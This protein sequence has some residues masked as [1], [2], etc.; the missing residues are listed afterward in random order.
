[1]NRAYCRSFSVNTTPAFINIY[2]Y[3]AQSFVRMLE[4]EIQENDGWMV[5][6]K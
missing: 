4:N 6:N 1:M 5:D 2:L 3:Q